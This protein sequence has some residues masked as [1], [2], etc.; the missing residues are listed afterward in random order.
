MVSFS[1]SP[2]E[3]NE[4]LEL[5]HLFP[6]FLPFPLS[7]RF[8]AGNPT[9]SAIAAVVVANIVLVTYV[10]IAFR[11]DQRD[12]AKTKE[13]GGGVSEKGSAGRIPGAGK[14]LD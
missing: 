4:E 9:Y 2:G 12:Q 5:T 10:T 13:G 3:G 1:N 8:A 14:K 7:L 6:S 11:E